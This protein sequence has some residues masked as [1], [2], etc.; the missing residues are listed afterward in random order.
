MLLEQDLTLFFD[1][2][3]AATGLA[4]NWLL[5][6]A[7]L[8][9][10]GM[11]LARW[12]SQ[13]GSAVQSHVYRTTLAAVLACPVAT[14][15]LALCGGS[16]WSVEMPAAWSRSDQLDAAGAQAKSTKLE[17]T[18]EAIAID[19]R[20]NPDEGALAGAPTDVGSGM[21]RVDRLSAAGSARAEGGGAPTEAA[22]DVRATSAAPAAAATAVS[23]GTATVTIHVFGALAA[24][25]GVLWI[26]VSVALLIRL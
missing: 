21:M 15:L 1:V 2:G 3:R 23:G 6:S 26:A 18:R 4:V 20:T 16:G 24:G 12:L 14:C 10:C 11:A 17:Q 19:D 8:I 9:A 13:R 25:I 22:T 7:L 5:Q